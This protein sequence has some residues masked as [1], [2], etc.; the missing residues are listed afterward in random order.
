MDVCLR[1]GIFSMGLSI[2]DAL[3][4][5]TLTPAEIIG[6]NDRK[7]SIAKNKDVDLMIL[8]ENA[9]VIMTIAGG[10]VVYRRSA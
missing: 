9:N 8:D 2:A 3:R 10:K 6:V 4:M 5:T 7:G 1:N